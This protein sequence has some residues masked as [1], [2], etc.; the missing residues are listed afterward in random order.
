MKD[1]RIKLRPPRGFPGAVLLLPLAMM[2]CRA[3][4]E[5]RQTE[6][7]KVALAATPSAV[8]ATGLN[9]G[10]LRTAVVSQLAAYLDAIPAGQEETFGFH[11]RGEFVSTTLG[12]PLAMFEL[13]KG[14]KIAFLNYW[15][16][17]VLVGDDF[18]AL[19]DVQRSGTGYVVVAIGSAP[20]AT[21]L[22]TLA[23]IRGIS[24]FTSDDNAVIF[25]TF[26]PFGDFLICPAGTENAATVGEIRVHPLFNSKLVSGFAN[27]PTQAGGGA[28]CVPLS[29]VDTTLPSLL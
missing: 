9:E 4:D 11:S 22:G 24:P 17:P 8:L 1:S 3:A 28:E 23:K 29:V 19:V 18:R 12:K 6:Y 13:Q 5:P 10:A 21:R 2:N 14:P 16:V 26:R 25:R 27:S 7:E 15:R 20:F